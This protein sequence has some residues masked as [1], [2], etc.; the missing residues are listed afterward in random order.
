MVKE[1]AKEEREGNC[2]GTAGTQKEGGGKLEL[3][4]YEF[5]GTVYK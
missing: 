4:Y 3:V 2:P 5:D 1:G